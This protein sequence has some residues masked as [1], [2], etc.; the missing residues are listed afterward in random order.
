MSEEIFEACCKNVKALK[1]ER[2]MLISSFN[3]ALRK[4]SIKDIELFTKI[5]AFLYSAYAEVSFQKLINIPNGFEQSVI[6]EIQRQRN[7]EEK[8][9]KCVN[10]ALVHICE[11]TEKGAFA[12]KSQSLNRIL[13]KYIIGPSQ[14]RNKIA[15]GQ[16]IE[17]LNNDCSGLNCE[18]TNE[19]RRLDFVKLDRLFTIYDM[20]QQCIIDLILSPRT[21]YRDFYTLMVK[22][23][24]YIEYTINWNI[25]SKRKQLEMSDKMFNYKKCRCLENN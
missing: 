15:H 5:Y 3:D 25:N 24:E 14:I 7:L 22:I 6:N 1:S 21:H 18:F 11:C 20:F 8:W 2:K 4:N 12:N 10:M 13:N 17:C 19:I 16:W 23:E 9:T